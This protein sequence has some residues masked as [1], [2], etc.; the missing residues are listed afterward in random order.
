[1]AAYG[2]KKHIRTTGLERCRLA[3]LSYYALYSCRLTK[4]FL[5]L[6]G[7]LFINHEYTKSIKQVVIMILR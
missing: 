4:H 7:D 1:M 6:F 2:P 5:N 3:P